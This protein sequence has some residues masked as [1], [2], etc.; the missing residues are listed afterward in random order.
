MYG[1]VEATAFHIEGMMEDGDPIPKPSMSVGQAMAYHAGALSETYGTDLDLDTS[2]G[3]V[4]VEVASG[5]L[6]MASY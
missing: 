6:P 3:M 2:V 4:E 1:H 5:P